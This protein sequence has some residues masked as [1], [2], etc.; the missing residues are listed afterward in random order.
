MK[1]ARRSTHVLIV[2]L[3]VAG[4]SAKRVSGCPSPSFSSPTAFPVGA[5]PAAIA[6]G[7]FNGD[8]KLDM[9]V[10]NQYC[11]DPTQNCDS[12]SILIGSGNGTFLAA[13]N[14]PAGS[15]PQAIAVGDFNG[16]N[17]LDLA[18]ANNTIPGTVS[19]LLG[20]GNGTFQ[21]AVSYGTGDTPGSVAIGD[22]NGDNHPDLA[23]ANY[24]PAGSVSI[25]LGKG[26]GTFN[27]KTNYNTGSYPESVAVGDFNEDHRL[28][29][30]VARNLANNV[31]K[32]LGN[33]DGTFQT[34]SSISSVATPE[35]VIVGDFNGDGHADVA[36]VSDASAGKVILLRGLG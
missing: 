27:P 2:A 13:V 23:V 3:F 17:K 4:I 25:L 31:S 18:V 35:S 29:L 5:H 36:V 30:V 26:D 15:Y 9:A 16:D 21:S 34:V 33:G 20:N 11:D 8:G 7:D 22:F 24:A 32:L 12:V 6:I 19:V 1:T 14:Y 28:D 10:A